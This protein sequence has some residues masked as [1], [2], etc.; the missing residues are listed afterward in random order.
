MEMLGYLEE[1]WPQS[2]LRMAMPIASATAHQC[3][4]VVEKKKEREKA[5]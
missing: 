3:C 2:W 5:I 4:F 1:T